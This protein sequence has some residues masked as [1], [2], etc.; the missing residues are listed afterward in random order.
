MKRNLI[1]LFFTGIL[2]VTKAQ[3]T[4]GFFNQQ[5]SKQKLMLEQIADLQARL[6]LIHSGY[7]ITK[8]GLNS[9][10]ELKNGTFSLNRAYFNSLYQVNPEVAPNIKTNEI[11]SFHEEITRLFIEEI[12]WQARQQTLTAGEQDYVRAVYEDMLKKCQNDETELRLVIT[13]DKSQMTDEQR[14]AAANRIYASMQEKYTFTCL[15]TRKCRRLAQERRNAKADDESL[16]KL[17]GF[18]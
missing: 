1:F 6:H 3:S 5:A 8:T 17:Y 14:L 13:P 9:A 7:N 10:R 15:F 12:R 11:H 4:A 16:K 2:V 18:N